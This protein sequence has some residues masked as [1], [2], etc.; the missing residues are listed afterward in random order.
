M[1]APWPSP[2]GAVSSSNP[3][4]ALGEVTEVQHAARLDGHRGA[5][6]AVRPPPQWMDERIPVVKITHH[7]HGPAGLIGGQGEGDAHS[8]VTS[9]LG[10][11]D[12]LLSPL[13]RS[14]TLTRPIITNFV[15]IVTH[16]AAKGPGVSR[17]VGP[18]PVGSLRPAK[19]PSTTARP[20]GRAGRGCRVR[21][22]SARTAR[23]RPVRDRDHGA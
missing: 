3:Y 5:V 12:Q 6:G 10:L 1:L 17:S 21:S 15:R 23:G 20:A 19:E 4:P 9:R 8:A 22:S 18:S 16:V 11:L 2:A 14:T 13:R 7:G